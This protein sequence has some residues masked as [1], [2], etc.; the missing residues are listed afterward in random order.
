MGRPIVSLNPRRAARGSTLLFTVVLLGTV[1]AFMAASIYMG[2]STY[3]QEEL[4]K[5]VSTSAMVGASSMYDGATPAAPVKDVGKA[6][7]GLM[8]NY[9]RMLARSPALQP[10]GP[11][12]KVVCRFPCYR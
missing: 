8:S 10:A 12:R 3:L 9:N 2:L 6:N 4:Q 1:L 5:V 11:Q 7:Q